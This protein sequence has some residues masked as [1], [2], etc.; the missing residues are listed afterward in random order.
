VRL[1]KPERRV[2]GQYAR[3]QVAIS[4]GFLG[5]GV[6]GAAYPWFYS[7]LRTS[8]GDIPTYSMYAYVSFR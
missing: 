5:E 2:K 8:I 3:E 6:E 4:R 7:A 1:L